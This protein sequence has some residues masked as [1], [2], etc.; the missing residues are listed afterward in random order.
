MPRAPIC[1]LAL[2]LLAC[3]SR[4]PAPT[5]E[6]TQGEGPLKLSPA[7]RA[8]LLEEMHALQ[9]A[10][11]E[12]HAAVVAGD[13]PTVAR[14]GDRIAATFIL[15]QELT[16]EQ[17]HELHHALPRD[18]L[19]LDH[20]FHDEG[21]WLADAA[22]QADAAHVADH[23]RTLA[24][25]CSACHARFAPAVRAAPPELPSPEP[26]SAAWFADVERRVG[27]ADAEG[28][29]P[30]LGS[31]EWKSAVEHR[32]GVRD[33]GSFPEPDTPAW[34]QEVQRRLPASHHGP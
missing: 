28:H 13:L 15:E 9:R 23:Y 6:P 25:A 22:R 30:D 32:L 16:Q 27:I 21:R 14:L 10:M 5:G 12:L 19:H 18:F 26:C 31:A 20:R 3:A 34:C 4:A 7:L 24:A 17:H 1:L 33:D 29:G 2:T 11:P 8:L